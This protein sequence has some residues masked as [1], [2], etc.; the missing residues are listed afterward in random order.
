MHA[1]YFNKSRPRLLA[2][3]ERAEIYSSHSYY[4]NKY[5]M[6]F[7]D[8]GY[9][10]VSSSWSDGYCARQVCTDS[11]T[12][13]QRHLRSGTTVYSDSWAAYRDV[14]LSVA[15]HDMV[16][17]SLNFVDPVSGIHTVNAESYWNVNTQSN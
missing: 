3:L 5:G 6:G 13:L 11:T 9:Q 4:S 12:N 17:H 2:A 7:W 15:Q 16:N 10:P 8:S 1:H 14:Q